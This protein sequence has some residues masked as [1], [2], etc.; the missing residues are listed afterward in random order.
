MKFYLFKKYIAT[1]AMAANA[2]QRIVLYEEF[3]GENRG[4]CASA[5]PPLEAIKLKKTLKEGIIAFLYHLYISMINAMLTFRQ[6][7]AD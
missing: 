4:P 2:Q 6:K 1:C 5:N 7:N 3:T